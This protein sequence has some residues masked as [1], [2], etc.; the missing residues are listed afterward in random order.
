MTRSTAIRLLLAQTVL[1]V[2]LAW[3][4]VYLGRDEFHLF[5]GREEEEVPTASHV[6]AEGAM[7][8]V[9]LPAAAQKEVGIAYATVQPAALS[10]LSAVG[11]T[12]LDPQPL[13]E[14]RGRLLAARLDAQ[15]ARVAA[16]ASAAEAARVRALFEDDRN[17]S[18]R[19]L[20]SAD[21][22]AQADVARSRSAESVVEALRGQA[23]T[24][25][26]DVIAGWLDSDAKQIERLV[27]GKDAL[28]RASVRPEDAVG[29]PGTLR[30]VLPADGKT[31]LAIP[32]GPAPGADA[33]H[34]GSG[35]LYRLQ[36]AGVRPGM[37]L[38][39]SL[40]RGGA[41]PREGALIPAAAVVWHAG[42]PWIYLREADERQP[43]ASEFRRR[44]ISGGEA[45]GDN[46]FVAG[47]E[48]GAE[49]VVRGAQV[50]L[51]EELKFQIKNENDD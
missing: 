25:W 45:V 2:L 40:N 41:A 23:R 10:P 46:W 37:R 38:A 35:L 1:M 19:A 12:V 27:A 50:L 32:I 5:G 18:Q 51:S 30:V 36:N 7:P 8:T 28:L 26:G 33:L 11:I 44:D 49:V 42:K 48:D 17:A 47:F 43:D 14:L 39:G 13:I 24:A 16:S 4:A 6:E 15:A 31:A 9:Q 3:A 20:Q 22:Q 34:G 21:A 29:A